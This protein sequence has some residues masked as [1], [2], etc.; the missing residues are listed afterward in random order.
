M[1]CIEEILNIL[2]K[3]LHFL[4]TSVSSEGK[5]IEKLISAG[6]GYLIARLTET[7]YVISE[8]DI[9]VVHQKQARPSQLYMLKLINGGI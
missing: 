8:V 2:F 1:F 5:A 9:V 4:R 7:G 3:A 6:V